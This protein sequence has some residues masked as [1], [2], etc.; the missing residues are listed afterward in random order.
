M[1]FDSAP[2]PTEAPV[3]EQKK[4][5]LTGEMVDTGRLSREWV[6]WFFGVEQRL[7][8]TARV[9][10]SVHTKDPVGG[11]MPLTVMK[12]PVPVTGFYRV[13]YYTHV[14]VPSSGNSS[15]TVQIRWVDHGVEQV[16]T[17]VPLSGNTVN[18]NQSQTLTIRCDGA[19]PISYTTIYSSS[20]PGMMQYTLDLAV[21]G[22]S[23]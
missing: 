1:A 6:Q 15:V 16:H 22:L 21:E 13:S 7:S 9:L 8:K 2:P 11:P 18:A 3:T 14:V 19:S 12:P 23:T 20:P 10:S 5:K 17:G 4:N